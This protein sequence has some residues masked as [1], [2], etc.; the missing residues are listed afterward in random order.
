MNEKFWTTGS[1]VRISLL[2][3]AIVL[4]VNYERK[5]KQTNE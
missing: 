4:I 1:I 2:A 3:V 5:K